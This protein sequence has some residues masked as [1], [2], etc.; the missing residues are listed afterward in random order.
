MVSSASAEAKPR[1]AII[2]FGRYPVERQL[3]QSLCAEVTCIPSSQVLRQG[4]VDWDRVAAAQLT[5]I[6]TGKIGKDANGK[7]RFV[8]L[9]V[10]APGHIILVRKKAQLS[11]LA[12]SASTLHRLTTD[13][14]G[15]LTR[16]HGPE[17]E[18]PAVPPAA[19]PKPAPPAETTLPAVEQASGPAK[20]APSAAGAAVPPPA[21]PPSAAAPAAGVAE[22]VATEPEPPPAGEKHEPSLLEV[23]VTL[24]FLNREFTSSAIPGRTPAVRNTFV[25]LA[26]EPTLLLGLF[27]LRSSSGVFESLGV[28]AGVGISVGM[29]LQRENDTSGATFPAVA[30]VADAS[31]LARLRLG[32]RVRLSPVVGWQMMNFDVQKASDGTVLTGQPGAHWRALRAGLKL[33][34]GLVQWCAVFFEVSYLYPY[35]AGPLTRAPYATSSSAGLSFDTALG[36]SFRLAPPLEVRLGV[37]FTRYAVTFSGGS[38]NVTG[39]TDQLVGFTLGFRYSY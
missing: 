35:S 38:A 8:D 18:A 16:A 34:V 14:V 2:P 3:T 31:L 7:K 10:F 30:L 23:Q 12:L 25:P 4:H 39:V 17:R 28:E 5:G 15:V 32:S 13:L 9:Q 11:N 21:A 6:V 27:P 1:I 37:A 29:E 19:A 22:D 24:A 26:A 33:D 36:L 20:A